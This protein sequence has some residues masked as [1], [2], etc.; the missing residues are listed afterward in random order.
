MMKVRVAYNNHF[1]SSVFR[2]IN[3]NFQ[4]VSAIKFTIVVKGGYSRIYVQIYLF[5][6]IY[7]SL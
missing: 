3:N 5:I 4:N 7:N 6:F 1:L 2:I